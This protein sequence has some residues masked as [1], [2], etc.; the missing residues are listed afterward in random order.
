LRDPEDHAPKTLSTRFSHFLGEQVSGGTAFYFALPVSFGMYVLGCGATSF[1][2]T[3]KSGKT[4]APSESKQNNEG[5]AGFHGF[6]FLRTQ[7][8][9]N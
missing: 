8:R 3:G 9:N 2:T 5:G 6:E 7:I 1:S 4:E